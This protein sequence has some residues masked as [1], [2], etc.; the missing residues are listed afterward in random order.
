MSH[1]G[2]MSKLLRGFQFIY[3]DWYVDFHYVT[4]SYFVPWT[5]DGQYSCYTYLYKENYVP[6]RN[7][8]SNTEYILFF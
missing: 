3:S 7:D 6:F 2:H 5:V 8:F 1:Y 4:V